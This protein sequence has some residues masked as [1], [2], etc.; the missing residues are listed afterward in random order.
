[1]AV[2]PAQ[3][4]VLRLLAERQPLSMSGLGALLVC[5]SGNNPSRLTG[6][7]PAGSYAARRAVATG[8]MWS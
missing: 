4:E 8:A 1:M 3:A 5:E 2:T 6:W 7:S